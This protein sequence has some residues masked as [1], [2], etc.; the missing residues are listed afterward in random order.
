MQW[1]LVGANQTVTIDSKETNIL[2]AQTCDFMID[3]N[4]L[5]SMENTSLIFSSLAIWTFS[6]A[7]YRH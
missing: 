7:Q 6:Q 2:C 3:W 4:V 1:E 5:Y